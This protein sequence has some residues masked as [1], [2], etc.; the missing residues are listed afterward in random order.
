MATPGTACTTVRGAGRSGR[1]SDE[2]SPAGS[3]GAPRRDSPAGLRLP[4]APSSLPRFLLEQPPFMNEIE[5]NPLKARIDDC[6]GRTAS[7][8]GYL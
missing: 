8:R 4:S 1:A 3:A 6:A 5:L 2:G 7:I